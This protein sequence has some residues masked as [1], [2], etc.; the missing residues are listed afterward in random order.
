MSE[1]LISAQRRDEL[2]KGASRRL[3]RAGKVLGIVYGGDAA[4]QPIVLEQHILA[5][6]LENEGFFSSILTLD[7]DG[8]QEQVVIKDLQRH[9]YKLFI[10]H[11]DLMR[12]SASEKIEMNI[13]IH[14]INGESCVGVKQGGGVVSHMISEIAVLCLPG[15]L[16]EYIDLDLA[17]LDIGDSVHLEDLILPE[18]VESALSIHGG[19]TSQPVVTVHQARVI[20]EEIEVEEGVE[21][22]APEAGEGAE[23]GEDAAEE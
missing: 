16:P 10:N 8:E 14:F 12:V 3:R 17:A 15:N 22:E 7:L 6:K 4:P 2:G 18:G 19:D 1:Y 20:E 5:H 11:I 9:P 21:G 23:S 13:P